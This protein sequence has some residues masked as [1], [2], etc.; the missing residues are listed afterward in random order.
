M[1]KLICYCFNHT[2]SDI[3]RD[4]EKKGHSLLLESIIATKQLG[5]CRCTTMHPE[6]R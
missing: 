6:T 1:D 2:E 4:V 3:R 5:S